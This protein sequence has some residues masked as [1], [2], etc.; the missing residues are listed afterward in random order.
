[1]QILL[2]VFDW[3]GH[4]HAYI[5]EVESTSQRR[6]P[7]RRRLW[8]RSWDGMPPL[9]FAG[10]LEVLAAVLEE[11]SPPAPCSPA[12]RG[13]ASPGGPQGDPT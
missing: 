2:K 6:H 10:V 9:E 7:R 11:A 4:W 1:M 12:E 5:E 3:D 13:S 8:T